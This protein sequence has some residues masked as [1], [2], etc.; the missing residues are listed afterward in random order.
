[1]EI[2]MVKVVASGR[3]VGEPVRLGNGTVHFRIQATQEGKPF[4][5]FCE[6]KTAENLLRYRHDGDEMTLEGSL[7]QVTFA[8]NEKPKM[9][10][11]AQFVSYGRKLESLQP[12]DIRGGVRF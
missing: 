6:G 4:H 1:M 12:G 10:V 8:G 3:M 11:K 5:C 2:R 9:L 7:E